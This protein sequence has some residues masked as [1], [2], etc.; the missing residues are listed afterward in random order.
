LVS[1]R[2]DTHAYARL[3]S[4][5]PSMD[6]PSLAETRLS[7]SSAAAAA[8]CLLRAVCRNR[9]SA[10]HQRHMLRCSGPKKML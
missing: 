9:A 1:F 6:F 4:T 3:W 7:F 8:A 2:A 5:T 10:Y